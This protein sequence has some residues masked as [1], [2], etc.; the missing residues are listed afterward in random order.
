MRIKRGIIN[1]VDVC[2]GLAWGDEGK[3]KIVSQLAKS[4]KYNFVCRF[5]G[6]HNAGHTVYVNNKK[7]K[8][9]LIP[10]GIFYGIPSI[11]GPGC[12]INIESFKKEIEYLYEAGFNTDLIKVSPKA[13][14][15]LDKHIEEDKAKYF[16]SQGSTARGIAP[17]YKD[18]YGRLG[19]RAGDVLFTDFLKS[20]I[21]DE[22]LYGNILCEG[23]QGLWLD[24][25]YGNYP[26]TTSSSTMPYNIGNLGLPVQYINKIYGAVK[27]Y[28]TR[29]GIDPDFPEDL[30]NDKE[31]LAIADEGREYGVTTG[32]RRKVNWL[33]L[34]KLTSAINLTGTTHLII[35]K[36]DILE[37]VELY[38]LLVDNNIISFN[39][40]DEMKE[41]INNILLTNCHLLKEIIYSG[42][43]EI[44]PELE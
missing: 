44:V 31:L 6:G 10:S 20:Y 4:G 15:I 5:N 35:S 11:I 16:V 36:V 22:N 30:L 17:C 2:C 32:R 3:G 27:I 14:V 1:L 18:K 37:K 8:T 25:D 28:D 29:S 26:Y 33:N 43:P 7:Y 23:A 42:D 39:S 41:Y 38:K 13:H 34:T 19:L 21:W 40:M 9:H 24:I 12:V